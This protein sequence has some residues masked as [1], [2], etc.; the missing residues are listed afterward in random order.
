LYSKVKSK[1]V[2][3]TSWPTEMNIKEEYK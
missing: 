3:T 1:F 2:E